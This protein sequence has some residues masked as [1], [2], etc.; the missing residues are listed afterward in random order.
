MGHGRQAGPRNSYSVCTTWLLK[1][2]NYYL[3]D[4]VRGRFDF[5]TLE[6][7]PIN[8][9]KKFKPYRILVEDASTGAALAPKLQK[10]ASCAVELVPVQ[11]DKVSRLF[12]QQ[13]KFA[14]GR[15]HLPEG[16]P[17]LP[18]LLKELLSFPQSRTT[19]QVD[20]IS[21]ALAYQGSTYTLAHVR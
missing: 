1:D 13:G 12:L 3:L 21:Q 9:A 15:V 4:L 2:D 6:D 18:D 8:Y 20:S 14:A 16:A 5:A 10:A 7:E 17:F 11:L 19:D